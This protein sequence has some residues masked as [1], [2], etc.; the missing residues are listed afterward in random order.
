[1]S[2]SPSLGE[3]LSTAQE[4]GKTTEAFKSAHANSHSMLSD[5]DEIQDS[6]SRLLKI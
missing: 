1:M 3:L 4:F 6:N 5:Q 2:Q